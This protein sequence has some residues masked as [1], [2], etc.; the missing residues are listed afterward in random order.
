MNAGGGGIGQGCELFGEGGVAAGAGDIEGAD[1]GATGG[2]GAGIDPDL[3]AASGVAGIDG[4]FGMEL[5][6]A[7]S[8]E[9]DVVEGKEVVVISI[10]DVVAD[11]GYA[12]WTI[13]TI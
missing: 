5:G 6:E 13:R 9:I 1:L 3:D 8:A 7:A 10:V 2:N 11:D 12:G 4:E